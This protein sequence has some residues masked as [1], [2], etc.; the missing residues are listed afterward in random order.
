MLSQS[1]LL[2]SMFSEKSGHITLLRVWKMANMFVSVQQVWH[3]SSALDEFT[4]K[5]LLYCPSEG[6][7]LLC[8]VKVLQSLCR[9]EMKV[10]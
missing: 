9:Q 4:N 5:P 2:F 1:D 10:A 7:S 3:L 8:A 6:L